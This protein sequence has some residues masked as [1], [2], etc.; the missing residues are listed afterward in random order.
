[1]DRREV[2][3]GAALSGLMG[4]LLSPVASQAAQSGTDSETSNA[5][6]ELQRTID[7][8]EADFST[9]TWNLRTAEDFAEA[10][11][12]LLHTL[13]HGLES[14]LEADPARPFFTAFIHQHKKLLGDNPDARYFSAVVNDQNGYRI[15][16]NLAD[17]T[18]TSF[19][20]EMGAG[21]DSGDGIGSTLNDTEF[22]ADE[23]GNYEIT[24]S[25]EKVKGNWMRLPPGASSITSRHY[26]ERKQSINRDRMHHIPLDIENLHTVPPRTA[27]SDK[28]IATGIRRVTKFVKGSTIPMNK[29]IDL[30]WIS[31]V[32][33]KFAPPSGNDTSTVAVA[34]SE[35]SDT[36]MGF[37]LA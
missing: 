33:N 22:E 11:R 23:D 18:Y 25:T 10:R 8:L 9:P 24:V 36:S 12:S 31:R 37:S 17:A 19:T 30:P 28:D 35:P 4:S 1:M 29:A 20:V 7:E 2:L 26:Y 21:A 16:G 15:R 6:A 3:K 27:P 13:L 14:W 5:L 34:T 32:P